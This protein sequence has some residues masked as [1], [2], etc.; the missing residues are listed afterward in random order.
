MLGD[1]SAMSDHV[2]SIIPIDQNYIPNAAAQQ[3]AVALLQ[4]MLPDGEMCEAKAYD[5]LQFIDQGE[6][7]EAVLCPSCGKRF[8]STS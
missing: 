8:P 6:N 1:T 2:L 5:R 7:C 4:E 3:I